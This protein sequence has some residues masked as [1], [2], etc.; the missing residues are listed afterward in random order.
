[1]DYKGYK[2]YLFGCSHTAN[3]QCDTFP[4]FDNAIPLCFGGNCNDKIIRDLKDAILGVT[5]NF[6]KK[7]DKVYF[8]IQ[9]TYFNRIEFYSDIDEKYLTFHSP[10]VLN[11]HFTTKNEFGDMY[12]KFYETWLTYFFDEETRLKELLRECRILKNLMDSFDIKFSWYL[13]AGMH[14]VET[15]NSKKELIEKKVVLE[16]EFK[17]LNFEKFDDYWYFEDYAIKHKLR[18]I[19]TS[20]NNDQHLTEEN[21]YLLADIIAKLFYSKTLNLI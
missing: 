14:L 10:N 1:M 17:E 9:F 8:N 4:F 5:D 13:W 19:D 3:V 15:T 12:D 21:N 16:K 6:T 7:A 11:Q 2:F 18:L 20:G